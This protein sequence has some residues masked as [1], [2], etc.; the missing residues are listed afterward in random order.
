MK[1]NDAVLGPEKLQDML[2]LK[3][4]PAKMPQI[5]PVTSSKR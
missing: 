1:E 3:G 5:L 4:A 2:G